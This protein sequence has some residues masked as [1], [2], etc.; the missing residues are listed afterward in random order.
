MLL[1]WALIAKTLYNYS[2]SPTSGLWYIHRSRNKELYLTALGTYKPFTTFSGV[3]C[4]RSGRAK[5]NG[6]PKVWSAIPAPLGYY[7]LM[8][9][10]YTRPT[11][12]RVRES[13]V[14]EEDYFWWVGVIP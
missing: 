12:H 6:R 11:T 8:K 1:H 3:V 7:G 13:I 9:F 2:E 14:V 5:W 4:A 10:S